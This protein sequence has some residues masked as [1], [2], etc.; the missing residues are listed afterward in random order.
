MTPRIAG[1]AAGARAAIFAGLG[2]LAAIVL[3]ESGSLQSADA[4]GFFVNPDGS[5]PE[6][7]P[8]EPLRRLTWVEW[9]GLALVNDAVDYAND[10]HPDH[11]TLP[12]E[13]KEHAADQLRNTIVHIASINGEAF[14]KAAAELGYVQKP[15]PEK[16]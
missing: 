4:G 10:T 8:P 1:H 7:R 9:R 3:T 6:N 5:T 14:D 2:L 15:R 16:Q 12:R 11:P 13:S